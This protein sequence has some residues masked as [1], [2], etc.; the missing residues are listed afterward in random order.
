MKKRRRANSEIAR[1][2]L[3]A[4]VSTAEQA[5]KDSSL[6]AQLGSLRK[7]CA[8][9]GIAVVHEY[10]EPG[11]SAT[12]D[13]RRVFKRM[14]EDVL[15]P[16]SDIDAILVYHTSRFMRNASKARAFKDVLRKQG[17]RVMSITQEFNDD[18]MGGFIEGIFELV[19]Q[20][21]SDVN[22]MRTAAAMRQNARHG[23]F[24]GS[25]APFGFMVE[26]V[27]TANGTPKN[28]LIPCPDEVPTH[29]EVFRAHRRNGG[30]KSTARDLNQ[31]G[32]RYRGKLFSKDLVTKIISEHAAIGTYYWGRYDQQTGALLPEEDWVSIPVTPIISQDEFDMS[33]QIRERLDPRRSPGRT[34]S[35]PLLLAGLVRCGKCGASYQL[36]SSGKKNADGTAPHRYYNCKSFVRTGKEKCPG[37]RIPLKV[38]DRAVLEHL[39]DKLFS[40]ERCKA[41]L[42]SV[43]DDAAAMKEKTT[44]HR[45]QLQQEIADIDRR[46]ERWQEAFETGNLPPDL[47]VTRIRSLKAKRD[48]LQDALAKIVPLRP[49]PG[50]L[51][52][53]AALRRFQA[54]L[55][56]LFFSD[57]LVLARHHLRYLVE[58]IRVTDRHVSIEVRGAAALKL[59][60]A[61]GPVPAGEVAH[62]DGVLT[63]VVPWLRRTGS[64][65]RHGG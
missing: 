65:C 1:A 38:L 44:E 9:R 29:N 17:V 35:S 11:A 14:L 23:F 45:Q 47:D 62:Q 26:K 36:E 46:I 51:Y 18:P 22:G 60:A 34:G 49:P 42:R 39:A 2:V 63:T 24:N 58:E 64:N 33:Q 27:S 10:V 3:Y 56:E 48:E 20:Y 41:L 61:G 5:E 8:E 32:Y 7:H 15:A 53:E 6:P 28:K 55:R 54:A 4:R 57:D 16:D 19:D 50:H 21:E 40:D 59:M 25:Q 31:R 37:S 43:V 13:N 12:D 52:T 30:A